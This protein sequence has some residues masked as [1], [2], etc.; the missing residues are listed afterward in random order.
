MREE[1][2]RHY[3][4]KWKVGHMQMRELIQDFCAGYEGIQPH[5]SSELFFQ[6]AS[7]LKRKKKIDSYGIC[8]LVLMALEK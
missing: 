3:A 2:R 1:V 6:A 8:V 7:R 4:K 5:I